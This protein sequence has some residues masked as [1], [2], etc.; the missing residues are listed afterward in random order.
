MTGRLQDRIAIVTGAE[1][2]IGQATAIA[3]AKAGADLVLAY[4]EDADAVDETARAVR[5]TGRAAVSV[6]CDHTLPGDVERLFAAA[7]DAFGPPDILVS[8]AGR[9]A[10]GIEAAEMPDE[11]WETMLRTDL[12]GPFL[13]ARAF[14]RA[15]RAAGGG[16]RIVNI[17]S[18]HEEIPRIGSAAYDAAKGG[19][20][21]LTRTLCL[22]LAPDR[23]AVNNIAPG[24]ILTAM[25]QAAMD[26]PEQLERQV[27]NIPWRRPGQPEEVAHLAVYLASPEADYVT[28]Q[29]FTI[30]GGLSLN[31]GQGA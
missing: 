25:N 21:N 7:A 16:G 14:I 13:C 11:T 17:S 31:V 8:A 12:F 18:V 1:S 30:D 22:E 28:G 3:F 27:R 26:D 20:R 24:M 5:A 6:Q 19:L 9:D 10:P 15:R 4:L 23:I 29:T 2:G